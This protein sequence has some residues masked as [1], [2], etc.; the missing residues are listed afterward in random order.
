MDIL[1]ILFPDNW[2]GRPEEVPAG[3]GSCGPKHGPYTVATPIT[4]I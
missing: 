3:D 1:F 4:G 2:K